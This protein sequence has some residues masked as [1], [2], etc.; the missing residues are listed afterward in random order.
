MS[1]LARHVHGKDWIAGC[2]VAGCR[3]IERGTV[4]C[5]RQDVAAGERN[6]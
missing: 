3:L 4:R 2:R 1:R 6:R 5:S